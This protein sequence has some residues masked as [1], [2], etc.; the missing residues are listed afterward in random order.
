MPLFSQGP[1][2]S[3]LQLQAERLYD[4]V[5]CD[6]S[7]VR[8]IVSTHPFPHHTCCSVCQKGA[9]FSSFSF[10]LYALSILWVCTR[11]HKTESSSLLV[12]S[13]DVCSMYTIYRSKACVNKCTL[14]IHCFVFYLFLQ[15]RECYKL[16]NINSA[17]N[18]GLAAAY[19]N[20]S[21]VISAYVVA[22]L[23]TAMSIFPPG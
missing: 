4:S 6:S 23:V 20:L 10:L 18:K 11:T 7:T 19:L 15:S 13:I 8:H 12:C 21:A 3:R 14:S 17:R 5:Y 22:L 2:S 16:G 1:A 9:F